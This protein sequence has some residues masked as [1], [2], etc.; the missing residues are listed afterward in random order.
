MN[1][2]QIFGGNVLM[3]IAVV[4]E[5]LL[6]FYKWVIIISA[7]ISWVHPDPYNPIVR[8]LYA[9]TEPVLKPIR[10]RIP[11]GIG[12]DISPIVVI[13]IIVFLQLAVV[14]TLKQFALGVR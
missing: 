14:N 8:F 2:I 5:Y 3:G 4:I 1:I 11:Y 13:L 6:D 10:R 9:A 12:I 7:L